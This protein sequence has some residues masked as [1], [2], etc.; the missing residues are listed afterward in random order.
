MFPVWI[1]SSQKED[2]HMLANYSIAIKQEYY[3]SIHPER[4]IL[5]DMNLLAASKYIS[6]MRQ[7]RSSLIEPTSCLS[8]EKGPIVTHLS[9]N[10]TRPTVGSIVE[11]GSWRQHA[12]GAGN[13]PNEEH[14]NE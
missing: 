11:V 3:I 1:S 5:V 9:P 4:L 14:N 10:E 6:A 2:E 8:W 7:Y 13:W 12:T